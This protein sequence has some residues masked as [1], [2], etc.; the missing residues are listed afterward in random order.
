MST[1]TSVLFAGTFTGLA[2]Y[3]YT[4]KSII[5]DYQLATQEYSEQGILQASI[6]HKIVQIHGSRCKEN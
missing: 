1:V 6:T 3:R 2:F 5:I 4:C